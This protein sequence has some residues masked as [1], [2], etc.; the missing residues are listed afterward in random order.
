[1]G[2]F[3]YF[4]GS[5]PTQHHVQ[6]PVYREVTYRQVWPGIDVV[7]QG[8]QRNLKYDV[9]LHPGGHVDDIRFVCEGADH[10]HLDDAGNLLIETSLGTFTDLKPFAYQDTGCQRQPIDCRFVL[11][12]EADG[13]KNI[14]FELM[15]QSDPGYPLVIDPILS[16]STYLGGSENDVGFGIAVDASGS[17]YVAGFTASTD[18]PTTPGAFDTTFNASFEAFVTK[19]NP[20]GTA[21][22]YSTYLGGSGSEQ[23]LGI[24]VDLSGNAYVA[25][26]TSSADFPTTPGAFDTTLG[27]LQNAFV[28][29]LDPAGSALVYSTYLGGSVTDQG[30]GIVL[31]ASGN[32]YVTGSTQ[33]ADFPVTPGA[34]DTTLSGFQNAFVTKLNPTGTAL[35]YSTYLGG[36]GSDQGNGIALDALGNAYVTGF[37]QSSDFPTTPGA[38]DT[39][40]SGLQDAF[41]TKLNPA[42]TALVYSTYLGG[43]VIETGYG[44]AVDTSDHAYVT[45]DT[46]SADFPTTPGAFDT[47][48]NSSF[49]AFVTKLNPAG[50]ALVY[51]TYLGGSGFDRGTDIALDASGT[52][53]VTGFTQSAD[54]PTTPDAF[55]NSLIGPQNVFVTKL[56]STGTALV[57][58]TYLGGSGSEQG[59]GIALD[60]FGNA[61]VA[62]VTASDDFPTTSGAFDSTF[63]GVQD[64]FVVKFDFVQS[65]STGVIPNLTETGPIAS[66]I[67]VLISNDNLFNV[68]T[69]EIE[70]FYLSGSNRV[71]YVHELFS[72]APGTVMSRSYFAADFPAYEIQYFITGDTAADVLV[73]VFPL[74]NQEN[75]VA[76]VSIIR[77]EAAP[78][79]R[80]TPVP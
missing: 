42:G 33:S 11:R 6:L 12:S 80:I 61:Y 21:L 78:L 22:V 34:F 67:Q 62:G 68:S 44:I 60:A 23:G 73:S 41:V 9:V 54:F 71:P 65:F 79:V 28:T 3:N 40:S 37:T 52:A 35:V 50:T 75:A 53:Y 57:Y 18:F 2:T 20:A 77:A 74:D 30:S 13:S 64:A 14:G 36:S 29:K 56:N 39:S 27:G 19:L 8:D 43:S 63:G 10:I 24:A 25:G 1:M 7:F 47:T 59:L 58:S 26:F 48:F 49:D 4:R 45:G 72:I 31:D 46:A 17:A 16:Y 70:A 66:T 5:N 76:A 32:A 55:E 38:F 51:S 69:I 15:E